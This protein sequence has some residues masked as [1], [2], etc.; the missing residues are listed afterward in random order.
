MTTPTSIEL[1]PAPAAA[2]LRS[3]IY[4]GTLHHVRF[5]PGTTHEFSY[6]V[7]M[8]FLD[9]AEI[10]AVT[11]LHPMWSGRRPAPVWFRRKDFLG[12]PTVPLDHAVRD[13]VAERSGIRPTGRVALLANLRTWGWLFN[14]ISLYFCTGPDGDTVEALVAEVENTPWHDRWSYVVDGPGRHRFS[15][16]M[17]V[18]PFLPMGVDYEMSYTAPGETLVVRFVVIREHEHLLRATLALRRR[19]LDRKAL[20]RIV[21]AYPGTTHRVSAGIYAQAARL[22]LLGAPFHSHPSI[23]AQ[24]SPRTRRGRP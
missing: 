14:P 3:A 20:G 6:D 15:K 23:S 21:W 19:S 2:G 24:R 4:E 10:E 17:H 9:L 8:P 13:L 12:D 11:R 5:G 18:S 7:A 1:A 16:K 22:K